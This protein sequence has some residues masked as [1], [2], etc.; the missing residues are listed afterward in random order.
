LLEQLPEGIRA[1]FPLVLTRKY[2]CDRAVVSLLHNRTLGNSPTALAHKLQEVH[3]EEW[4][5]RQVCYLT[6]CE[7]HRRGLMLQQLPTP[8]YKEAA[9]FPAFPTPRSEM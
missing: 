1:H 4:V 7:R 8:E 9:P 3:S 2:A 5:R 6:D